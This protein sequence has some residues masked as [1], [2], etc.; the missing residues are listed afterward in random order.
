[1]CFRCVDELNATI[2]FY[3]ILFVWFIFT[4]M[5][6]FLFVILSMGS[7]LKSLQ[8]LLIPSYLFL[9]TVI[10]CAIGQHLKDSVICL[11]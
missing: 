4:T 7:V 6:V 5:G 1:M 8:L 11:I 2:R 3:M 10:F 9:L